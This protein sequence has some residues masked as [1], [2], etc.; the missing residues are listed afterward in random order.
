MSPFRKSESG[1]LDRNSI[2]HYLSSVRESEIA[3]D[4]LSP[5][6][7]LSHRSEKERLHGKSRD[8]S[9]LSRHLSTR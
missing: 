5:F 3:S 4:G 2:S 8:G 6:S 1:L 7:M 9:H